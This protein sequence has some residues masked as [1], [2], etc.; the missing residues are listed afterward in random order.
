[1]TEQLPKQSHHQPA[2]SFARCSLALASQPKLEQIEKHRAYEPD[3]E[4]GCGEGIKGVLDFDQ[5]L[6]AGRSMINNARSSTAGT[7]NL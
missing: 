4:Q 7:T 5:L 1:M 2:P 6:L 3:S